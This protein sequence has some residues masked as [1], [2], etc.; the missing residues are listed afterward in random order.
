MKLL[1][2]ILIYLTYPFLLFS[3][4]ILLGSLQALVADFT[5]EN[6]SGETI[7]VTPI[8]S[9]GP[10]GHR[11]QL[12]VV[13]S[14]YFSFPSFSPGRYRLDPDES[15]TV[16][17]D[18][19]DINFSEIVIQDNKGQIFQ[20]VTNPNPTIKRYLGPLQEVYIIDS[21]ENL[22]KANQ[23]IR[24]AAIPSNG[25]RNWSVLLSILIIGPWIVYLVL[26]WVRRWVDPREKAKGSISA[27]VMK[28]R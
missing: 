24:I 26:S 21:L 23:D 18:M 10:E 25:Q 9:V 17:Y 28:S 2:Q 1:L 16:K 8:G 20:L 11:C 14:G 3:G 15:V 27:V 22:R 7:W 6:R 12:P 5:I 19:D 13:M 4:I